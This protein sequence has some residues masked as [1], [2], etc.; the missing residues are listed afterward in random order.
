MFIYDVAHGTLCAVSQVHSSLSTIW[1]VGC[2]ENV[3]ESIINFCGLS[4]LGSTPFI[5]SSV[6]GI[7]YKE[8]GPQKLF[9]C[10]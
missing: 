9:S 1:A 10:S 8:C 3:D 2:D 7:Y 6:N 5:W 4:H